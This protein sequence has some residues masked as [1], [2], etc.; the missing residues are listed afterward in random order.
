MTDAQAWKR[1]RGER[2]RR[3]LLSDWTQ[4]ADCQLTPTEIDQATV[5]RQALRDLPTTNTNPREPQFPNEPSFLI[6]S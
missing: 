1:L 2:D 5:Y 4:I 3:L 6:N